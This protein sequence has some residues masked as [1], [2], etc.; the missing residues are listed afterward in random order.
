MNSL[1]ESLFYIKELIDKGAYEKDIEEPTPLEQKTKLVAEVKE[2]FMSDLSDIC[3]IS[4]ITSTTAWN[5]TEDV[6]GADEAL[7]KGFLYTVINYIDVLEDFY[8]RR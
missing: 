7:N 5:I 2:L 3:G 4:S 8:V 1:V 6:V